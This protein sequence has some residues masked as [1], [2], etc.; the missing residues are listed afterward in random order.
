MFS[1]ESEHELQ[2]PTSADKMVAAV[3][4]HPGNRRIIHHASFYVDD[5]GEGRRR[6]QETKDGQG[7]YTS[8]GGPGIC[9]RVSH[10]HRP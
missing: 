6:E 7:G 1:V 2:N 5:K 10:G 9:G 4:F 3:E 8:F